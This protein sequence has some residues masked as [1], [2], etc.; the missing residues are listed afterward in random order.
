MCVVIHAFRGQQIGNK[1]SWW[2]GHKF[3][4]KTCIG[5]WSDNS[6]RSNNNIMLEKSDNELGNQNKKNK[7]ETFKIK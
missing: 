3:H 2:G 5:S 1:K 6:V 4:S 7:L